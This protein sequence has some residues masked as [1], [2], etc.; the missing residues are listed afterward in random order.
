MFFIWFQQ[1]HIEFVDD[2]DKI[3]LEGPPQQVEKAREALETFARELV[4]P[5]HTPITLL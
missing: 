2:K 1:L 5:S 4:R 3:S